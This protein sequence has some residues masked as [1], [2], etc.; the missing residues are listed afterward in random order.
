VAGHVAYGGGEP[1]QRRPHT[2]RL[3]RHV[4]GRVTSRMGPASTLSTVMGSIYVRSGILERRHVVARPATAIGN[5]PS[6]VRAADIRRRC[7][8]CPAPIVLSGSG[9]SAHRAAHASR[10]VWGRHCRRSVPSW[11]LYMLGVGFLS[12]D[13]SPP[14]PSPRSG[15]LPAVPGTGTPR[16]AHPGALPALAHRHQR[17][18]PRQRS[19]DGS[20]ARPLLEYARIA[21]TGGGGY[22]YVRATPEPH[23]TTRQLY[24]PYKQ[25]YSVHASTDLR[26]R[27]SGLR[28]VLQRQPRSRQCSRAATRPSLRYGEPHRRAGLGPDSRDAVPRPASPGGVRYGARCHPYGQQ[29]RPSN[30]ARKPA[31]GES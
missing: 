21:R 18:D 11:V 8:W 24:D 14:N 3:A 6:A 1:S 23:I 19:R 7:R 30:D 26:S 17:T 31:P 12:V 9:P 15:D 27:M 28:G 25:G 22:H 13:T 5:P 2:A 20:S 4:A 10:R 16:R 29:R